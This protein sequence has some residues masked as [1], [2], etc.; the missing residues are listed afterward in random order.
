M[1]KN[2]CALFCICTQK[3]EVIKFSSKKATF[4]EI[5]LTEVDSFKVK[6]V[7]LMPK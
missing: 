2:T 6:P 1:K 5:N 4:L 7:V 3:G